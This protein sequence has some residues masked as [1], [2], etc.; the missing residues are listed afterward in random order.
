MNLNF[1]FSFWTDFSL[2]D[3]FI[4]RLQKK[5]TVSMSYMTSIDATNTLMLL[6]TSHCLSFLWLCTYFTY[7]WRTNTCPRTYL[8]FHISYCSE[9]DR[10]RTSPTRNKRFFSSPKRSTGSAVPPASYS[11]RNYNNFIKDKVAW[12]AEHSPLFS[13]KITNAWS[14]NAML[15]DH[16]LPTF[17]KNLQHKSSE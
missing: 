1:Y 16:Q 11:T 2:G 14:Y 12:C 7:L 3:M 17:Q 9:R 13:T 10:R 6:S 4:S 8:T 15:I 5:Y